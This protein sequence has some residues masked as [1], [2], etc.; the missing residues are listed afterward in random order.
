MIGPGP[1]T[2]RRTEIGLSESAWTVWRTSIHVLEN[3]ARDPN[4]NFGLHSPPWTHRME[5]FFPWWRWDVY[6]TMP[7]CFSSAWNQPFQ[8]LRESLKRSIQNQRSFQ[9]FTINRNKVPRLTVSLDFL[10]ISF[11][12]QTAFQDVSCNLGCFSSITKRR[13]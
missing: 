5:S 11:P 12:F 3:Q 10:S 6:D 8:I 1:I 13:V 4:E 7:R 9:S 2:K